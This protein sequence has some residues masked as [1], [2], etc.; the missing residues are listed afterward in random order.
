MTK[1]ARLAALK[2]VG[3]FL[4]RLKGNPNVDRY[5]SRCVHC[6]RGSSF[7]TTCVIYSRSMIPW[8]VRQL[9]AAVPLRTYGCSTL[10]LRMSVAMRIRRW[11]VPR[12]R[13]RRRRYHGMHCLIQVFWRPPMGA[14]LALSV[15]CALFCFVRKGVAARKLS[16]VLLPPR[17]LFV[18]V[19]I[20][21][22]QRLLSWRVSKPKYSSYWMNMTDS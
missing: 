7:G 13:F 9:D 16:Q 3:D 14:V 18:Y 15:S 10:F 22:P 21:A 4:K 11:H 2:A 8:Y 17:G 1:K 20:F 12:R 19:F 6:F 5:A